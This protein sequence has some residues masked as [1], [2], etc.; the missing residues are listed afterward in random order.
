MGRLSKLAFLTSSSFLVISSVAMAAQTQQAAGE[1]LEEVIVTGSRIER[2]G[3][4][5]PT[6]V[7]MQ[8]RDEI[9]AAAAPQLAD[10][11]AKLPSFGIGVGSNN[12]NHNMNGGQAGISL[13][14]LRNLGITRTLVLFDR[15]RVNASTLIGGVDMNLIPDSVVQ[16]IDVVTGGASAQWGSDAVAGVVNI[17]TN[18]EYQ[19]VEV[20]V[21]AGIGNYGTN[22]THKEEITGGTAFLGGKGHTVASFTYTN[23]PVYTYN[24]DFPWYG[25][26]SNVCLMNNTAGTSPQYVPHPYCYSTANS[27]KG[28]VIVAG[29]LKGTMFLPGGQP[30]PY[31]VNQI[32]GSSVYGPSADP[33]YLEAGTS[34]NAPTKRYNVYSHTTYDLT[35]T[36]TATLELNYSDVHSRFQTS[37]Y[38][39]NNILVTA[40]NAFLPAQTRAAM[41]AA[42]ITS[43][44][45]NRVF[46]DMVDGREEYESGVEGFGRVQPH[47]TRRL[48]R[49]IFSLNG[50]IFDDWSW[51]AYY[52]HGVAH[53]LNRAF[54][55][56][57]V[58]NVTAAID[59]V[60]NPANGQIVCRSELPGQ[61]R[62][63]NAT[64]PCVPMNIFG[65]GSPSRESVNY[66]I[67]TYT[68]VQ[69]IDTTQDVAAATLTGSP[70]SAPAGPV[71]IATGF[72][73]RKETAA[74]T[75]DTQS[76]NRLF[77]SGN[78]APLPK[79]GVTVKE[80]FGEVN[81]PLFRDQS[82]ARAMDVNAAVRVT[83]YSTSGMVQT[84]KAGLTWTVVDEVRLRM[85]RSR[86]IRAPTMSEL[87]TPGLLSTVNTGDPFK[88]NKNEQFIQNQSGNSALEPE[89]GTTWTGGGIY[90]PL[91][92]EGLQMSVDYYSIDLAGAVYQPSS[93]QVIQQCFNGNVPAYCPLIIRE[94]GQ[95]AGETIRDI[96]LVNLVPVN[97]AVA[98]TRGIDVET[99]Y[100]TGIGPGEASFRVLAS[101][102]FE[103]SNFVNGVFSD[104]AG[105]VTGNVPDGVAGLP[106]LKV[107]GNV[108]Y[109]WDP[110]QIGLEVNYIGAA[111]LSTYWT[112]G[113]Q[114][115][116]NS[117]PGVFYFTLN[118]AYD[119]ELAETTAHFYLSVANLTDKAPP[120]IPTLPGFGGRVGGLY[121]EYGRTFR[122]GVRV[123]F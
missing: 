23:T 94:G 24:N 37:N 84:W 55:N 11:L 81:V 113:V 51:E 109:T 123:K 86:D 15:H 120:V 122:G 7:T 36:L 17:I 98:T 82:F 110:I 49:G 9:Q 77:F 104:N 97:A 46:M 34:L 25:K 54:V 116:D 112:E 59:A 58:P 57:Y 27:T 75:A 63:A 52:T 102:N 61:T 87:F 28:G 1:N 35:D 39:R 92:L 6:P 12:T 90:S 16:R 76:A 60:V 89:I 29:P 117:V 70:F 115:A 47:T 38:V 64:Y 26:V 107:N 105:S 88:N 65:H 45:M 111:K 2:A 53:N 21:E 30:A 118:A 99:S 80:A 20:R 91:W 114:V 3:Y 40:D 18:K 66:V 83:D 48:Y 44:T 119:L 93:T 85:T 69:T 79:V 73:W 32:Q 67:N 50:K 121:E 62:I 74:A 22:F 10:Y 41:T 33:A 68:G 31:T 5:A 78:Y 101:Y 106:K 56:P 71:D 95:L 14:N 8:N 43:F 96:S 103:N 100:S 4:E 72:E 19:G 108:R 13:V 42:G